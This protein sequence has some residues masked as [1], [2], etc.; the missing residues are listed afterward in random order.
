MPT[1]GLWPLKPSPGPEGVPVA[2]VGAPGVGRQG[3]REGPADAVPI[4]G[5][6]PRRQG[7]AA[8]DLASVRHNVCY[9]LDTIGSATGDLVKGI[10][11]FISEWLIP[12]TLANQKAECRTERYDCH[13]VARDEEEIRNESCHWMWGDYDW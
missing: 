12:R 8:D 5:G 3:G 1:R 9:N 11:C 4:G 6:Q 7:F 2:Q 10:D 13:Q